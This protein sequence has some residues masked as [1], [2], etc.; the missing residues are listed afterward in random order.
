MKINSR[1]LILSVLNHK[2]INKIPIDFGGTCVTGIHSIIYSRLIKYLGYNNLEVKLYDPMMQLAKVDPEILK[3]FKVDTIKLYRPK[4]KF[5]ISLMNG[6]KVGELVNGERA[7]VPKD[8][9][10]IKIKKGFGIFSEGNLVGIRGSNSL[11]FDNCYNFLKN[12]NTIND[13][14]KIDFKNY[15]QEELNFLSLSSSQLKKSSE[16]AIIFA[17]S[18]SFREAPSDL[19]GFSN[20][21]MNLAD[22]KKYIEYLLDKLLDN[23]IERFDNFFKVVGDNCDIL[24]VSD[25]FGTNNG[26]LMSPDSYREVIKPR[27][28]KL[29][30][31]IKSKSNYKIFLHSC[32]GI[33]DIIP[34]LIDVGIDAL[35]PIQLN[36]R[37]M[38]ILKL[39]KNFG[40]DIVF[41][42]GVINPL[43][44][45]K[46][47]IKEL[48]KIIIKNV[49]ILSKNSG[50]VFS[51]N[52]N[53]QPDVEPMKIVEFFKIPLLFN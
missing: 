46:F 36:A 25:D 3:D 30:N 16:K 17:I 2:Q 24:K 42:G 44:I 38:D 45:L 12:Y 40:K 51:Y 31:Y 14:K 5:G 22:N 18:G 49:K 19:M 23:Y 43:E 32:G 15:S 48:R 47:N 6:W 27:Q 41:W 7:L 37:G 26:L 13:L 35:N 53:I 34:D 10:P 4:T 29:F 39:K 52:H 28:K 11:Y 1:D 33:S 8:Y 20:F 9:N 21:L 50:F